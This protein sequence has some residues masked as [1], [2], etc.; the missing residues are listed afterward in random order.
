MCNWSLTLG[1]PTGNL[2]E[3]ILQCT[4]CHSELDFT[5]RPL[6]VVPGT[7]LGGHVFDNVE[8][9]MPPETRVVASNISSDPQ[10]VAFV[11][12]TS[13]KVTELVRNA[14]HGV[15]RISENMGGKIHSSTG[16]VGEGK[17]GPLGM[18]AF[19]HP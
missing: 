2:V 14:A 11:A 6:R 18:E 12:A 19:P 8:I 5:Q 15:V 16:D 17:L 13:H 3:G 1:F 7:K 9:G 10:Y 4:A